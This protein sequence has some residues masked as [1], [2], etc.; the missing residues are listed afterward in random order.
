MARMADENQ[1]GAPEESSGSLADAI[2]QHLALKREHGADE[3]AVEQ[4]LEEALSPPRRDEPAP[5]AEASPEAEP[6][7]APEPAAEQAAAPQAAEEVVEDG[8]EADSEP[9]SEETVAASVE[10]PKP[11]EIT[12][13]IEFEFG[14]DEGEPLGPGDPAEP[15]PEHD[16]LEETPDFFE[17]TPEHDKL[18]F[19]EA[20]PRKF[21]F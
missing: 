16:L 5:A 17:E 21:D 20:P 4:E 8:S 9:I 12:G 10:E 11:G 19:D 15:I 2:A 13:T 14:E 3:Q 18:W 6:T 1:S 7:P